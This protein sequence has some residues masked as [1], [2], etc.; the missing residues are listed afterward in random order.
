MTAQFARSAPALTRP[1]LWRQLFIAATMAGMVLAG[2]PGVAQATPHPRM[3]VVPSPTCPWIEENLHHSASATVMASQVMSRMTPLELANFVVLRAARGIENLNTGVPALCIP[4]LTLVDG[5]SGVGNGATHVTQFPSELAIAA[6]FNPIA[7]RQVGFAMGQEALAKGYDVLQGPD[8]NLVRSP[9]SGRT[10]ETYGEDPFLASALGVATIEGIQS[11]GEL[12]L[13]KHLGA[14]TQ[15]NGRAR[16]DQIVSARALSEIYNAPFRAAVQQ[17]HV[18]AIMC[19][20]GSLNRS[21]TCSSPGL[22]ATLRQW[23]FH[24]FVR[25]DYAAVSEPAPAY[26]A[27]ISLLKPTSASQVLAE[28][29]RETLTMSVLRRDVHSVLSEMFSYG[30]FLHPRTLAHS[31]VATSAAHDLVALR[32]ERQGI[33]L[34]QNQNNV[35]PLLARGSIAV[36]GV[37]GREGITT[38][39]GGSSGVHASSLQTPLA[40][41]KKILPHAHIVYSPGGLNGLEFEPLNATDIIAGARPPREVPIVMTGEPGKS[42][43]A[44][45]SA[46][47]VT[48]AA[49]TATSPGTGEGWSQWSVAFKAEKTGTYVL[50][51]DDVG[52]T[53]LS[54]NGRVIAADRGLHGPMPQSTSVQLTRGHSYHLRAV[55]FGVSAKTTPSFGI[56]Y[57]QPQINAAVAAA[58]KAHTAVVFVANVLSEGAD[59]TSLLLPGGLNALI[60]AVAQ[61][62]PRTVV[63]LNTGGPVLMPWRTRVAGIVE[64]WYGG[65]ET[66]PALAQVLAGVVDPSGRLP[67]TMPASATQIPAGSPAQY[68]GVVGV[69]H[70]GGL[71]DLGY[72]WYQANSVSPAF[73]FGFG[74][75]YTTFALNNVQRSADAGGVKVSLQVTNTGRRAGVEV[76]QVYVSYPNPLGEPPMQLRGFSRVEL[77]AGASKNTNIFL[78]RSSFSYDSGRGLVVAPGRYTISVAT[79]SSNIIA[80]LPVSIN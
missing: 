52:D 19:A 7:A 59:A 27:G 34:L 25:S 53:W 22:Y 66:G 61:V 26:R 38:R 6:S 23:G 8:L 30:L 11:T 33:V 67:V 37:D 21:N 41:L 44:I 57:I 80:R 28:L 68:P 77:A 39:G 46:P 1:A 36:I 20:M 73:P 31:A 16:I 9:L 10:F 29:A 32:A 17:A 47:S 72:R 13:A 79:S 4:P 14:Y 18:A 51:L 64:G 45:D 42:D 69:V 35:L 56:D 63:V 54:L 62:N 75:S 71:T 40:A 2:V 48:A 55:W 3:G 78:P 12:A 43:V 58:R 70:F 50:G 15:E 60:T 65:Q 5:P 24:G 76:V 74:L 49:L